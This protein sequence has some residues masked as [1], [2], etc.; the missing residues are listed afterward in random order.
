MVAGWS[1]DVSGVVYPKA[2]TCLLSSVTKEQLA[3]IT[4]PSSFSSSLSVIVAVVATMAGFLNS[5]R[6]VVL[7]ESQCRWSNGRAPCSLFTEVSTN[8][9]LC[10]GGPKVL[11]VFHSVVRVELA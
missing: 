9:F 1:I 4:T 10:K 11:Y 2:V 3:F 8:E 7:T 5:H 6:K